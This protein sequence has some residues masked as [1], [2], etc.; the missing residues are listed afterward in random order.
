MVSVIPWIRVNGL[1]YTATVGFFKLLCVT[2]W[3]LENI[4][5][6][7]AAKL[8][9]STCCQPNKTITCI[10]NPIANMVALGKA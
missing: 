3:K 6:A 5:L 9:W 8:N 1:F 2:H 4:I 10:A 7:C